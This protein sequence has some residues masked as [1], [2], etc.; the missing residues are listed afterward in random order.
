MP[1]SQS[2]TNLFRRY[3]DALCN[4]VAFHIAFTLRVNGE[5]RNVNQGQAGGKNSNVSKR[6]SCPLSPLR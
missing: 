6:Y 2:I 3:E 4:T 1:V 5:A